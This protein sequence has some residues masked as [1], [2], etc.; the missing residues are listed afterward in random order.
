MDVSTPDALRQAV[1]QES[2]KFQEYYLWL[3]KAMPSIFFEEVSR[4]NLM[5]I[6]HSLMGFDLQDYFSTIN[7][8]NAAIALCLDSP[9]A[10]LRILKQYDTHGIQ[11][12]QAYISKAP[13]PH[14][15]VPLRVAT[16]TF[17]EVEQGEAKLFPDKSRDELHALI[18]KHN[19]SMTD[20]EFEQLLSKVSPRFLSTVPLERLAIALTMLYHAQTRDSCQY[21][22]SYERNWV[23]KKSAS[24]HV[25]L[26]WR[27]TSKYQF[28]YHMAQVIYRHRLSMKRV[29]STYVD[30]YSK[31]SILV[32]VLSLHGSDGQ[33][34]WD[35]ANLTDFLRELVTFKYFAC[36]DTIEKCLIN[37]QII[38]GHMG[39]LLRA[40]I[41][42]IHQNLVHVDSNLYTIENIEEAL[43]RHPE[44]TKQLCEAFK[45]K[46]DPEHPSLDRFIEIRKQFLTDVT[47]LDT[48]QEHNDNRR[49][50]VLRQG[51]NFI[52]HV[53]KTN[54]YRLNYTALSFRLDPKYLDEIPF[55]RAKK[56]PEMPFA[57]FFICGLNFFGFHIRFKDLARGGLRT[58]YPTHVEQMLA[59]RNHVFTECYNLAWTQ[60]KKNKDIPEGGAK[61]IIF[62][63][64]FS[65]VDSESPILKRELEV[66][67]IDS[68]EI[69]KKI[70]HYRQEQRLEYLYQSQRA[71][72]ESLI[73]IVNCDPDGTIR[74]KHIVDYWRRPEYLYLGPDEN[75][76]DE[77]I[78]WI[79]NFS[80]KNHYKPGSNFISSKPRIGINHK[81][82]GVTSLGVNVYVQKILEYLG[83]SP[84]QE[85]FTVKMSGGPDGDVAGNQLL[86]FYHYYPDTAKVIA[87]TDATGTIQDKEGLD[88][89][90][91]KDLFHEGKG[92]SFYPP[93]K[94]SPGGFLVHKGRTRY[95]SPYIQETLCWRKVGDQLKEEWLSG[96][97]TNH[98]LRYNVHQTKADLFI[99]AGGRPRTLNESNINEF[100]DETGRPTARAIV[101]GVNLYLTPAARH[102]LESKGVLIIKDSSANKTGVICSSFEVLCGLTLGEQTFLDYKQ[103]LIKEILERL[104]QYASNEA[105][106]LLQTHHQTREPLTAISDRIS[107]HINQYTY[108][109][110]DFL[111][112]IPLPQDPQ[113]PMI[114]CFLD[115]CLPTLKE[116]FTSKLL[117]EIP[118]HHKKAIIACHLSTYM[119]YKKG[120]EWSP[121]IVDI[122]PLIL[123]GSF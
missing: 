56:F 117:A 118:E 57:I 37:P 29:Y 54:F 39:N 73:T 69:D 80:K 67:K 106:L 25:M 123:L 77:M 23:E 4:E 8:K 116:K 11:S 40:M 6:T 95:P 18:K 114:R 122:F 16:L 92:I 104:K 20:E 24:M 66:A 59:E 93:E 51:M 60:H 33:P 72:I 71:F 115:Y 112:L 75:M 101:E 45:Y 17:T 44:L 108:Q 107:H 58:V 49:K 46:F 27:N 99:P 79:A 15:S 22:V 121:S 7:L 30:P 36:S 62:L 89:S 32:M 21:E 34:A 102:I 13:F 86:N 120:L 42:F 26:A 88:L 68:H 91:L 10:D 5:L 113:D 31:N 55:E 50:N 100:L 84:D 14:V 52:S 74:A 38:S 43:C 12:Y 97:E 94:L 83:F 3:E 35:V 78:E 61:G 96:S 110:L 111:D 119:V 98:L 85:P 76:H 1:Q 81:E 70:H 9:D 19:S 41:T 109:L 103:I 87:L 105:D 2:E 28:L 47:Q 65:Q 90:I 48:G 82:Y 53:L 63:H 64:P